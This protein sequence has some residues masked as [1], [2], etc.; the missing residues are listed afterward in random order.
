[1]M[2]AATGG[3]IATG[4]P[5]Q[6][7][8]AGCHLHPLSPIPSAPRPQAPAGG[9]R[10]SGVAALVWQG[11]PSAC[12]AWRSAECGV[13]M[14]VG[15]V[16]T[17]I[18]QRVCKLVEGLFQCEVLPAEFLRI[19]RV[20]S[21]VAGA[22]ALSFACKL[23]PDIIHRQLHPETK[24]GAAGA[25]SVRSMPIMCASAGSTQVS[26]RVK[27]ESRCVSRRSSPASRRTC[28]IHPLA[29]TIA[30]TATTLE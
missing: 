22:K 15:I 1:M 19:C 3:H 26:R 5:A 27:G 24:G 17:A 21:P 2:H 7:G 14:S 29:S 25:C 28:E 13:Q 6:P 10:G 18:T 23:Y 16:H 20:V 4:Q 8:Q 12:S 11:V 30:G 9:G